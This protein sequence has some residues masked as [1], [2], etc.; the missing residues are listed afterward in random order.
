M[1]TFCSPGAFPVEVFDRAAITSPG[2]AGYEAVVRDEDKAKNHGQ[3]FLGDEF[4]LLLT[5]TF[6]PEDALGFLKASLPL[7][8]ARANGRTATPRAAA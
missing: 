3:F 8:K 6:A 5:S 1:G 7:D 2:P 4:E